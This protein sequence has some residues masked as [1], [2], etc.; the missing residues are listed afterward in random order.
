N[1]RELASVL[2]RAVILGEGRRLALEVAL[3]PIAPSHPPLSDSPPAASDTEPVTL[4]EAIRVHIERALESCRGKIDGRGGAAELLA[5]HPSTL[6]AKMR[7]LG[8][9]AGFYRN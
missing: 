7:K 3:G 6:R 4:N 8:I 1:V 2:E 5:I 9:A